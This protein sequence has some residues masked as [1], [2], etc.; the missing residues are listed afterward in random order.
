MLDRK[1][2]QVGVPAQMSSVLWKVHT[3][4]PGYQTPRLR[5]QSDTGVLVTR[6]TSPGGWEAKHHQDGERMIVTV[7]T[8]VVTRRTSMK[9]KC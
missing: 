6:P 5:S 8:R 4:S 1:L 7:L 2:L 9:L 3:V